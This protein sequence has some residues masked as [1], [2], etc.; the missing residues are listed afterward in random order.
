MT[1]NNKKQCTFCSK[2]VKSI[3]FRDIDILKR[4]ISSQHKIIDPIH[5][6]VCSKHQRQLAN[7]IKR[8]RRMA[9]LPYQGQ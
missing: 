1:K 9:L 3:D 8:A 6:G 2:D 7:A 4:Y 5:T